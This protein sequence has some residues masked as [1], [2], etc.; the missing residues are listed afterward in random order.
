M[1][2]A[3]FAGLL[4]AAA[5]VGG[6]FLLRPSSNA[7]SYRTA[8]VERGDLWVWVTATGNVQPVTQVQVGTQVSG[9]IQSLGAD[10]NSRVTAGQIIAQ[11]DP[12]PFQA[13]V[14][15][16]KANL[17]RAEADVDRVK[18]S[19]VQAEKEHA[20]ASELARRSL[21][22]P[23][24]LD[25][26]EA[27]HRSLEAQVKV[28]QAA[29]AQSQAALDNSMVNLR[30]TTIASPVDG[31]VISRNVDVGQT[32]AASLQAPTLFLIATNLRKIQIQ[33][34][35]S[36]ADI[37]RIFEG[38]N[39]TFGVDAYR[40]RKFTGTV[41]QVRLAPTTVQNVVTYTV[42]V[43]AENPG[44]R[45]LPGMT[46]SVSFEVA[47]EPEALKVPNAALRFNPPNAPPP[48]APEASEGRRR[49][50]GGG[51]AAPAARTARVWTPSPSGPQP[52]VVQI[53]LTDGSFTQVMN[54]ALQEGQEVIVGQSQDSR[55]APLN[56][57][58]GP[59]RF[60]RP[61]R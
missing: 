1:K 50:R 19:L 54:G 16:D 48:P 4:L 31:I 20:R 26:A 9:T 51:S 13:R 41:E 37:G 21:I 29:V 49:V 8:K 6:W 53:G 43:G 38:Q 45:L 18:A 35:V 17:A 7:V 55:D 12:A 24:E 52:A 60:G 42:I 28:S 47:H 59:P 27:A 3:I 46:A 61:S 33:A 2:R 22:S 11:I 56:N 30:Y 10:F 34:S 44:E 36:E 5:A 39:V 57:P 14:E 15:Q 40:E 32:V 23:S 25:A 58:F